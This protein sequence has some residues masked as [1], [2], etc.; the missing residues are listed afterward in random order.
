MSSGLR[1]VRPTVSVDGSRAVHFPA[2][3]EPDS[4]L[5]FCA[6]L[7]FSGRT[8]FVLIT[9]RWLNIGTEPGVFSAFAVAAALGLAAT[10][11]ALGARTH[12]GRSART[13]RPMQWVVL[14]LAFSGCS[15]VWTA[16]A[17]VVSSALYWFSLVAD[18]G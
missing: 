4:L 15:L 3:H 14:Y 7:L 6:G 8:I 9:G 13:Y 18:V 11:G 17:S 5:A 12:I 10:L 16:S 1:C 2:A